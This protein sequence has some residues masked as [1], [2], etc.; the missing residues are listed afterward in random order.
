[1][2]ILKNKKDC[3]GCEACVQRCPKRCINMHEDEEGFLYPNVNPSLCIDCGFCE[4]VCPVINQ[5]EIHKPLKVYAAKNQ[6]EQIRLSSSSGGI[7]TMLAEQVL[8]DDGVVFG[9]RFNV[10]WEVEHGYADT[11]DGIASFRGSK[12]VQSRIGDSYLQVEVLLKQGRK[13]LFSGTPCQVAGLKKYLGNRKYDNLLTV[14]VVCH[15]VPSPLVWR[16]YLGEIIRPKGVAGKNTVLSS[17]NT[18]PV[19][20]GISFRDKKWGW[21]KYGFEIRISAFEADENSVLKSGIQ[22]DI[23]LYEP[24]DKN[25]FMKGFLKNLY[26]RPSCYACASRSGKSGSDITLADYWGIQYVSPEIDDDKG[27]SLVFLNTS[28]GLC[29]YDSLH[30]QSIESSYQNALNGNPCI[31]RSIS[32]AYNRTQ[33]F[34]QWKDGH[35]LELINKL[36][37]STML[38]Q[39]KRYLFLFLRKIRILNYCTALIVKYRKKLF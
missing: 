19:I 39:L 27:V 36:T 4:K 24:L 15:G 38:S 21:K 20:T 23:Y 25:L 30:I 34:K 11:L 17:L 16:K 33:F 28:K 22:E 18:I 1:M 10:N 14:D 9:A 29:V 6:D 2:I 8:N 3:C 32:M 35:L 7:F 26:L 12:Y 37:K 31:E 5:S 13:V